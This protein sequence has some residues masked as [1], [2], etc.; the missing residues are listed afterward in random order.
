MC[1]VAKTKQP[2]MKAVAEVFKDFDRIRF[3]VK[4]SGAVEISGM[5]APEKKP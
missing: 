1:K 2:S 5:S 4:K 3:T